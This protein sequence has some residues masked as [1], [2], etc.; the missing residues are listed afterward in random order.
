MKHERMQTSVWQLSASWR[1]KGQLATM[2]NVHACFRVLHF[3]YPITNKSVWAL[4]VL[5]LQTEY[6]G[7][8]VC[9]C[10]VLDSCF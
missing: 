5:I 9:F 8:I 6:F 4:K 10:A 3:S 7:L 1:P 2:G